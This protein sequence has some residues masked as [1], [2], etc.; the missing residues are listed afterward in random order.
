MKIII[1]HT[2][3]FTKFILSFTECSEV[4]SAK[5]FQNL[6]VSAQPPHNQRHERA[7]K[8][9]HRMS[10]SLFEN[11]FHIQF[12]LGI[13]AHHQKRK[14]NCSSSL[15]YPIQYTLIFSFLVKILSY[16]ILISPL[17]RGEGGDRGVWTSRFPYPL[18]PV[19]ALYFLAPAP[20]HFFDCEILRNVA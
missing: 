3:S 13:I 17:Y 18:I 2:Q 12:F 4:H 8:F 6:H 14:N 11:K 16:Y 7:W 20:L 5:I 9:C 10:S 1:K 15:L 19:P